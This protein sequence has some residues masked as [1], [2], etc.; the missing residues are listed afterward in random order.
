MWL[1]KSLHF[2]E[3]GYAQFWFG[4]CKKWQRMTVESEEGCEGAVF[5]A[6]PGVLKTN[7]QEL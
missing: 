4:G 3:G 2:V 1:P 5:S 6:Q 7:L